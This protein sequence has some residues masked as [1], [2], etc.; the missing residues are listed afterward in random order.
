MYRKYLEPEY[1]K[2]APEVE[3]MAP[4]VMDM[5]NRQ[6]WRQQS[7]YESLA[8]MTAAYQ[9]C[10]IYPEVMGVMTE[11]ILCDFGNGPFRV[12]VLPA[13]RRKWQRPEGKEACT[14]VLPRGI[15]FL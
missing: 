7:D 15:F 4:Q 13:A 6:L 14:G 3:I 11:D 12:R 9:K 5:N 8:A 2:V 10:N 1:G